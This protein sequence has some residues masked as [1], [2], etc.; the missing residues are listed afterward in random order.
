VEIVSWWHEIAPVPPW[1][2][3]R[4]LMTAAT[5]DLFTRALLTGDWPHW[6]AT[7]DRHNRARQF[8]RFFRLGQLPGKRP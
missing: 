7:V 1:L 2:D 5:R 6:L 4:P 8:R 3:S